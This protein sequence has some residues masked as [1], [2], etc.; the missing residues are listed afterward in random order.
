MIWG[1]INLIKVKI[2]IPEDKTE[3]ENIL[4]GKLAEIAIKN[5][6]TKEID[7]LLKYCDKPRKN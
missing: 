6:T 4:Y 7:M 1:E 3:I 5:C 2:N